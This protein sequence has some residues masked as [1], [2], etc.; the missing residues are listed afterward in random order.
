MIVG[1]LE[2]FAQVNA[3]PEFLH[4]KLKVM[5]DSFPPTE[6][7]PCTFLLHRLVGE[8]MEM[9]IQRAPP[10]EVCKLVQMCFN[11]TVSVTVVD[12]ETTTTKAEE[13]VVEE[14]GFD[15]QC[16]GCTFL[17][18]Q[19]ENYA[20]QNKSQ[21]FLEEKL[22]SICKKAPRMISSFCTTI[23]E[24]FG[25]QAINMVIDGYPASKICGKIHMCKDN[26]SLAKVQAPSRCGA[27]KL[28]VKEIGHGVKNNK[29]EGQIVAAL[30]L[31]CKTAPFPASLACSTLVSHADEVAK[32]LLAGQT[33]E[34]I[35][36][37]LKMCRNSTLHYEKKSEPYYWLPWKGNGLVDTGGTRM[38]VTVISDP[39]SPVQTSIHCGALDYNINPGGAK[40][41]VRDTFVSWGGDS[42]FGNYSIVII[43]KSLV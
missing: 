36:I 32:K 31:F 9:V 10:V 41:C 34:Q 24:G 39:R 20:K 33:P 18:D 6:H 35:C 8:A 15:V 4:E 12:E 28:V 37:G 16:L 43:G 7:I 40:T 25:Q 38:M 5:C 26:N 29:T 42:A 21:A 3:T 27:C 22:H 23:V 13:V 2:L 11:R 19:L 30:K 1:R 14:E 17:I